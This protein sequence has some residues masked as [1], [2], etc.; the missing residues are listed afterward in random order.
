MPR[1][2][3]TCDAAG[4]WLFHES[5]NSQEAAK[6]IGFDEHAAEAKMNTVISQAVANVDDP[7]WQL[8]IA[9]YAGVH[10]AGTLEAAA[11]LLNHDGLAGG[12]RISVETRQP[13]AL[14]HAV[15]ILSSGRPRRTWP[16]MM[17]ALRMIVASPVALVWLTVS[18]LRYYK[19]RAPLLNGDPILALHGELTNRTRHLLPPVFQH[20]AN[21]A[22]C[23]LG[24]PQA[25]Q[26]EV[27][28]VF[29]RSGAILNTQV[30]YPF[31]GLS[32]IA[33]MP[34]VLSKLAKG[35]PIVAAS[36]VL[37]PYRECVG[38]AYR[39][40]LG[41]VS[42]K[43]WLRKGPRPSVVLFGHTGVADSTQLDQAM[44]SCGAQTV[45]C[46][47]GG[48]LGWNFAAYS[49]LGLFLNGH[50]ADL[51]LSFP[52][53]RDTG[54]LAQPK[55]RFV[56][57]DPE[58]W[59]LLTAYAHPMNP[60]YAH[61]GIA[62]DLDAMRRV[63]NLAAEAP[64]KPREI[65]WRPH[66]ALARLPADQREHLRRAA[67]E[68][69][70]LP[71][72]E[73]MGYERVADFGRIFSTPSTSAL[74]ALNLGKAVELIVTAP[75]VAETLYSVWPMPDQHD[76][77][78]LPPE[79]LFDKAWAAVRPGRFLATIDDVAKVERRKSSPPHT[80]TIAAKPKTPVARNDHMR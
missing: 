74:D 13:Q 1:V 28:Q 58:K 72:P 30:F 4:R 57:G 56:P 39:M 12:A 19:S 64:K 52:G 79:V 25:A 37:L 77:Q 47:H 65:I 32:L 66:P 42:A 35:V 22:I 24:R 76:G 73:E 49:G 6:D 5:R 45:H 60:A 80:G 9:K 71:W 16:G 10:L 11:R 26:N 69:G 50:D 2:I 36:P 27:A 20:S 78:P 17:A 53:Y 68:L 34:E 43:W 70:L 75:M 55:P 7:M 54:F 15:R 41:A 23:I 38:I 62:P 18:V 67:H 40:G 63:A 59:L 21:G 61:A 44:Q 31:D 14:L 29:E 33:A 51:G 48:S 8:E 3:A 46:V